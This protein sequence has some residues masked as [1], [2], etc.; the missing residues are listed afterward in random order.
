MPKIC[1]ET[2][3]RS[4]PLFHF[5]VTA[6]RPVPFFTGATTVRSHTGARAGALGWCMLHHMLRTTIL[7]LL[8]FLF[9]LFLGAPLLVYA[10]VSGNTDSLYAVGLFCVRLVLRLG[11]IRLE[12]RGQEKIPRG[13]AAVFMANHQSNID[14]PAVFASLP[15]VLVLAKHE[16]FRIPVL[17]PAMRLRGFIPVD[18]RDR[19]RAI[20]CVE[21]ASEALR[22]G[23]SFLVFP[24]GTRSPDGR[25]QPLKKGGFIMALNAGA[26][27]VPV[28][29]SGGRHIMR[30][31]EM[32][33]RPGPVR[34]TFH[35]PVRTLDRRMED[36]N[37]VMEEVREA[38][39]SGLTDEERPLEDLAKRQS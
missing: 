20:E 35:D 17:G 11:G 10:R 6:L 27:I 15:P 31:G 34:I 9:I 30:K 8:C 19:A 39:L 36:R 26:P 28:S 1:P 32:A 14:P 4:R 12:V 18:R 23:K 37:Q 7:S 25:L 21:Q 24:E 13:Q 5:N 29:L 2:D 22:A 3:S 33:I 38:L 16:V